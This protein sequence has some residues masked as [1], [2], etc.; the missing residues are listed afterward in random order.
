MKHKLFL[1]VI[2]LLGIL[3][4]ETI[5]Q[6]SPATTPSAAAKTQQPIRKKWRTYKASHVNTAQAPVGNVSA[7]PQKTVDTVKNTD[8]S[9]NGQYQFLLSRSRSI[10]GY[11]LVNPN[12]LNAVWKSVTDTLNKERTALATAKSKL[13]EQAGKISTLQ[14]EVKGNETEVQDVN[15]KVD[16]ITLLGLSFSKGTY[17]MIVWSIILVLAIALFVVIAR[18]AKSIAEAKHRTQLYD[19]I[20]TE[21]QNYKA[22]ASEKERKLARELQDER[23]LIEELRSNSRNG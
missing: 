1:T 11:K 15:A 17:N 6:T 20:S 9:L 7:V 19:E 23:N 2:L 16:E 13:T 5:A 14:A 22:K 18:S 12:R 4:Q 10:N 3:L 21:Y 8:F